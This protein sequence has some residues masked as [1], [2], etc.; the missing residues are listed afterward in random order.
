[1]ISFRML[2]VAPAPAWIRSGRERLASWQYGALLRLTY[3]TLLRYT[4]M[5]RLHNEFVERLLPVLDQLL[6]ASAAT[7]QTR[8]DVR[9]YDQ[10]L[11][12]GNLCIGAETFPDYRAR[13]MIGLLLDG[14]AH[15]SP[16]PAG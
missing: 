10:M 2:R 8:D 9:A 12:V 4:K 11:A 6:A 16:A 13:G 5:G 15:T 7:G 14:L 1:V 3:G